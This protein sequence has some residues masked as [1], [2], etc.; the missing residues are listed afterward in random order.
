MLTT[1]QNKAAGWVTVG[2]HQN[3]RVRK[4]LVFSRQTENADI[5]RCCLEHW[6][7]GILEDQRGKL[8]WVQ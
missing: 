4:S 8:L 5:A 6:G 1:Y 2:R 3:G 7:R